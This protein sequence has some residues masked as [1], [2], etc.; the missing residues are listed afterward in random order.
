MHQNRCG[1]LYHVL[2][3]L[4]LRLCLSETSGFQNIVDRVVEGAPGTTRLFRFTKLTFIWV[5]VKTLVA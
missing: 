1:F 3:L 4:M 5:W 2:L